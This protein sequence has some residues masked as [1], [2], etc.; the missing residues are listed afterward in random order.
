LHSYHYAQV[1]R[2]KVA[3]MPERFSME[4][5]GHN[6]KAVHRAYAKWALMKTPSLENYEEDAAAKVESAT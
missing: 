1:E 6:N 5:L 3:G 2:A 4:N